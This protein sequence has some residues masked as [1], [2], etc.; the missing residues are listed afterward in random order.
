MRASAWCSRCSCMGH[1]PVEC[2]AADVCMVDRPATLEEL[3][4]EELRERWGI[5]TRTEIAWSPR[6]GTPLIV[7]ET[8]IAN[9][10]SIEIRYSVKGGREMGLDAQLRKYMKANGI[11]NAT[12]HTE[13]ATAA[14]LMRLREWAVAQ[15]K[16]VR[17]V[18]EE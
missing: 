6:M 10:N 14:N 11:V 1:I 13:H 3:I 2:D 5:D 7:Q 8:E 18:V 16:K 4:P 9:T 17:L 15:G 12:G